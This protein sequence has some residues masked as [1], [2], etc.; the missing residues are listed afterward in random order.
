MNSQAGRL[1]RAA[2]VRGSLKRDHASTIICRE[3]EDRVIV[4]GDA[5]STVNIFERGNTERDVYASNFKWH[6]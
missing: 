3:M 6:R 2:I 4:L 5:R 1:A